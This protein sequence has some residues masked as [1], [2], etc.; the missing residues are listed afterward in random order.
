MNIT[1]RVEHHGDAWGAYISPHN[2]MM[3][4]PATPET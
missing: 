1:D 3:N 4:I 2:L